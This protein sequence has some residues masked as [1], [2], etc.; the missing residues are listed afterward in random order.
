MPFSLWFD[1][2]EFGFLDPLQNQHTRRPCILAKLGNR[3]V[4]VTSEK[5][6]NR[7]N[8][9]RFAVPCLPWFLLY[10]L[11]TSEFGGLFWLIKS[12]SS[13]YWNYFDLLELYG[14]QAEVWFLLPPLAQPLALLGCNSMSICIEINF[15]GFVFLHVVKAIVVRSY[16]HL[17]HGI[18][19]LMFFSVWSFRKI[20]ISAYHAISCGEG[21]SLAYCSSSQRPVF[22]FGCFFC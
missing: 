11:W 18:S 10:I 4:L 17:L 8:D 7:R 9:R 14:R 3:M 21:G 20:A 16:I 15:N 2:G 6:W 1:G 19:F 22:C 13:L 12:P 5:K